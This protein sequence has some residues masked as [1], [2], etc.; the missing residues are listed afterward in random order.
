M[1]KIDE[2]KKVAR[3]LVGNDEYYEKFYSLKSDVEFFNLY[4]QRNRKSE[5]MFK[6]HVELQ[7]SY[8][9]FDD[10]WSQYSQSMNYLENAF[11]VFWLLKAIIEDIDA[12]KE[13]YTVEEIR[14][15]IEYFEEYLALNITDYVGDFIGCSHS[16][17][18]VAAKLEKIKTL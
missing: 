12:G 3:N 17:A 10:I 18:A 4:M 11:A 7:G 8:R 6:V 2:I 15:F 16:G 9:A 14:D 5:F 1:I 13:T